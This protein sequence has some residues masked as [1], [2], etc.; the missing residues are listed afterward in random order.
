MVNDGSIL[1]KTGRLEEA[2]KCFERAIELDPNDTTSL[3]NCVAALVRLGRYKEALRCVDK[4]LQ[5]EPN[6]AEM[7]HFREELTKSGARR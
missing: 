2:V 5:L 3:N 4:I 6:N 1:L 7:V